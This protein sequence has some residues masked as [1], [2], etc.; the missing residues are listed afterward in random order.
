MGYCKNDSLSLCLLPK[1]Y[2]NFICT[3]TN[4][5]TQSL[6]A[7]QGIIN[8]TGEVGG[9]SARC[10]SADLRS[11]GSPPTKYAY[12]CY[13]TICSP[14][15]SSLTIKV[16]KTFA[17]CKIPNQVITVKGYDGTIQCPSSFR[18]MCAVRRCKNECNTNGVCLNGRCLCAPNYTGQYCEQLS[19][20]GTASKT[21]L[22]LSSNNNNCVVGSYRD[23]FGD[24]VACVAGCALCD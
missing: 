21:N 6:A 3:D 14:N 20:A 10:Y 7:S 13:E 8:I 12:R 2:S 24:C 4:Y 15:Y 17:I 22:F 19:A 23:I 9:A 5:A 18:S 1:F 11:A 16:G